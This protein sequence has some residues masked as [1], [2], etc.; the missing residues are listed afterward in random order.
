VTG[1]LPDTEL[2]L[3]E[4]LKSLTAGYDLI[5]TASGR[6]HTIREWCANSS[7]AIGRRVRVNL[8]EESFEGTTRG[9]E[10]DGALRVEMTEGE[11]RVVRAGDVT[12]LRSTST[13]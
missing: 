4:L 3:S 9:I 6:E 5:R 12:A 10:S 13:N 8:N 2:L 1:L 7:Y 11:I